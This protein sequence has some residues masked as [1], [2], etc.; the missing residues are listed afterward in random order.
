MPQ[1]KKMPTEDR[2]GWLEYLHAFE[3][4]DEN[5]LFYYGADDSRRLKE[6]CWRRD[7][8]WRTASPC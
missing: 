8:F 7:E 4:R 1:R 6:R 2:S 3:G 5:F